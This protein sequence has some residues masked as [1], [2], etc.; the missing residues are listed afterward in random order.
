MPKMQI[1]TDEMVNRAGIIG[2]NASEILSSQN[3]V[4]DI[5]QNMG[6]NFSGKIPSL[7]TQQMIAM[8]SD[9]Q[10]MN[11]MLGNYKTFLEDSAQNYEW[12]EEELARWATSL[13]K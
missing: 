1:V 4:T 13:G 3:K 12:T 6:K 10:A 7:M 2:Q 5:F 8:D 9:Y 11:T